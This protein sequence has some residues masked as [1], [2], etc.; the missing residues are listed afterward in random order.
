LSDFVLFPNGYI[1]LYLGLITVLTPEF[2]I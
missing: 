1:L 2:T